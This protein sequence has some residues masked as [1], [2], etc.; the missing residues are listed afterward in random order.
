MTEQDKII[1]RDSND[2]RRPRM[3]IGTDDFR[4]LLLNSDVFVDKS[5]LIKEVIE[6][7]GDVILITRPRRWG[8]SLNLDMIR[9][10]LEAEVDECGNYLSLEQRINNKLFAGGRIDLGFGEFKELK[11]LKI[12]SYTNIIKRQG[13]FPVILL[14]LKNVKGTNYQEIEDKVRLSVRNL[15]ENYD[16]LMDSQK[17][18]KEDKHDFKNYLIGNVDLVYLQN[19]LVFLSKLLFQHFGR[20]CYILIDEYD[21]PI[22][23]TY[24]EF[25]HKL[26]EFERVLKLFRG[27]L[28]NSLKSNPYIDRG[29]ITGIFR[30]A[31]AN[32]FSDLNNV[33]EYT[34][35][36]E[37]FSEFYGFTQAEVDELLI[38]IPT[39]IAKEQIKDWYNGYTFGGKIIY[40][41]WSIMQ[42]L[43]HKGKLDHYWLDSGG[44][45]LI[46]KML[47]SDEMQENLQQLAAGGSITTQITKQIS[48]NDINKPIGLF[49]LLLFSGYLNPIPIEPTANIYQL[50]VPNQEIKYIY[51][52]R[53]LQ[54][55]TNKLNV[56]SSRYYSFIGLLPAGKIEEFKDHL[57]ELLHNAT[58]FYQTGE[59]KAELFYSGFMLG[60]VNTL[61]PSHIIDSERE[62]G[63]G[64]ADIMLIPKINKGDL[65]IIIEYKIAKNIEDLSN[66]ARIGLNQI[67]NKQ[68]DIKI[69]EHLHVKKIVKIAMVFCGQEVDMQYQIDS[70]KER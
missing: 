54:W 60:L 41:P 49:S 18:T 58:S 13:Q 70:I 12:N 55:V 20:K 24:L 66:I 16:Y 32:L 65:A 11:P 19:S 51:E 3:L 9:R 63:K 43:A 44:T 31:K 50:S 27:M 30:I 29:L 69:K 56:D 67:L 46:D 1:T 22:N 35:V 15:Y 17:I 48:F 64:R 68:Y 6:D 25:E 47:I 59:R 53:V 2:K 38:K 57:Q 21:T 36:D 10:F 7:S 62:T 33:T 23:N 45:S 52:T 26:E 42:C 28:G 4:K 5:L 14:N 37:D 40:N 61:A 34:L 8:K 39:T